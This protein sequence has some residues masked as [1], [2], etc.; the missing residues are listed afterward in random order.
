MLDEAAAAEWLMLAMFTP[1][2]LKQTC[3]GTELSPS[4]SSR[5]ACSPEGQSAKSPRQELQHL[6]DAF[7]Q[8]GAR[9]PAVRAL[10]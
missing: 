8:A 4:F 10:A 9:S 6:K 2:Q 3:A 1:T 7:H 5:K